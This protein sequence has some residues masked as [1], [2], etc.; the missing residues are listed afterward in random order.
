MVGPVTTEERD[1]F[2]RRL[3]AGLVAVVAASGGLTAIHGGASLPVV[4][5]AVLGGAV[6]G[7]LLV[8]V[9]FP[10]AGEPPSRGGRRGRR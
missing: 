1:S 6:A 2:A 10:G 3:K 9:V 5:A 8:L 7:V 4:V